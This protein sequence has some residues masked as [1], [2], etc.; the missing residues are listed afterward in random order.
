MVCRKQILPTTRIDM[1]V[2]APVSN[3]AV[4]Q[5]NQRFLGYGDYPIH[6]VPNADW[7]TA[8][9]VVK[10]GAGPASQLARFLHRF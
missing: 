5:R 3:F 6:I 10:I 8:A 1:M 9:L 2:L 4:S 7:I